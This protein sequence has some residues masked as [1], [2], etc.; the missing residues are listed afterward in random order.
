MTKQTKDTKVSTATRVATTSTLDKLV[1]YGA[2]IL[3]AAGFLRAV[4]QEAQHSS[5]IVYVMGV[6][7]VVFALNAAYKVIK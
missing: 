7:V 6:A 3:L 1:G 2:I 4:Q 5:V